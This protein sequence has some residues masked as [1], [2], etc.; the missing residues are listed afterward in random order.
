MSMSD[1][2]RILTDIEQGNAQLKS[3]IEP[4]WQRRRQRLEEQHSQTQGVVGKLGIPLHQDPNAP[5]RP[6]EIRQRPLRTAIGK[7]VAEAHTDD[8]R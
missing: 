1:V 3:R 2:T 5:I 8:E 7:P 4:V 6:V